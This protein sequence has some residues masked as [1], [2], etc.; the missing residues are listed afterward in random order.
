MAYRRQLQGATLDEI[1]EDL[2]P[3][4]RGLID[5]KRIRRIPTIHYRYTRANDHKNVPTLVVNLEASTLDEIIKDWFPKR[6]GL[7]DLDT[8]HDVLA[9][10]YAEAERK[11]SDITQRRTESTLAVTLELEQDEDYQSETDLV[12]WGSVY[13]TVIFKSFRTVD[14][15]NPT[16]D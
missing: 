9:L 2:L 3:E 4:R 7:I 14:S 10:Y 12:P 6:A 16:R 8:M 1:I 11:Q 13:I 5:K 15:V